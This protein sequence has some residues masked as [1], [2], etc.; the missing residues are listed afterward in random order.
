MLKILAVIQVNSL[1]DVSSCWSVKLDNSLS[2]NI[3]DDYTNVGISGMSRIC[4]NLPSNYE[5]RLFAQLVEIL[6]STNT[7]SCH[8]PEYCIPSFLAEFL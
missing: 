6:F 5:N 2:S 1:V 8:I 4:I 3:R 7:F